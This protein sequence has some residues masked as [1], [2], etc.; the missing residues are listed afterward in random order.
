MKTTKPNFAGGIAKLALALLVLFAYSCSQDVN[1]EDELLAENGKSQKADLKVLI[2]GTSIQGAN[3]LDIG[4][5]GNLYIASVNGRDITVMDKN[6]GKIIR[7]FDQNNGILGPDD[8]V[9]SPDGNYLYW[10]DLL[11]GFVGRMDLN[12]NQDRYQFVAPGVNPIGFDDAGRLFVALD[13]LGDGLYELDPVLQ[14][15]TP[16]GF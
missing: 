1:L 14:I 3:G 6:N 8:L 11:T 10:T 2:Q 15:H 4:P 12:G 16:L 7:K 9:I 5:D 13:F